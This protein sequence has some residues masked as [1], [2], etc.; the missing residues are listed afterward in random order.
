MSLTLLV[1]AIGFQGRLL[2]ETQSNDATIRACVWDD[3][4][5]VAQADRNST[6]GQETLVYLHTDILGTPRLATNQS[7]AA[8]WRWEGGAFGESLPNENPDGDGVS[9]HGE[10]E[11][12]GAVLR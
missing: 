12:C 11:V 6:T 2:M 8:V 1:F 9:D 5:P 4:A 10:P 7:G 3:E